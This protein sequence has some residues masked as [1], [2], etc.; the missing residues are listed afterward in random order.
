MSN[1]EHACILKLCNQNLETNVRKCVLKTFNSYIDDYSDQLNQ[2]KKHDK[3]KKVMKR[4]QNKLK[5]VALDKE[6]E[7]LHDDFFSTL[8]T[9]IDYL[10]TILTQITKLKIQLLSKVRTS[11]I[12]DVDLK[13]P[14]KSEFAKEILKKNAYTFFHLVPMY[15]SYYQTRNILNVKPI[16]DSVTEEV[17]DCLTTR[18]YSLFFK[19]P[20]EACVV[21]Q[22]KLDEIIQKSGSSEPPRSIPKEIEREYEEEM[23]NTKEEQPSETVPPEYKTIY[24]EEDAIIQNTDSQD[25]LNLQNKDTSQ[26]EIIQRDVNKKNDDA[27]SSKSDEL[28]EA[29]PREYN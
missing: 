17:M 1:D 29:L 18:T 13:L 3:S 10:E 22:N 23:K 24:V 9:E 20:L 28:D 2:M 15:Y 5:C 12:N 4:F 21:Y 16:I 14:D 19:R 25:V 27:L 6:C 7:D 26:D 8:C 11:A